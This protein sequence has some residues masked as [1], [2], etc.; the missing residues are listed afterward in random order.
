MGKRLR[1]ASFVVELL[2]SRGL[3][4][5]DLAKMIGAKPEAVYEIMEGKHVPRADMAKAIEFALGINLR[6]EYYGWGRRKKP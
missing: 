1:F 6:P 3:K 2:D 4:F 5:S